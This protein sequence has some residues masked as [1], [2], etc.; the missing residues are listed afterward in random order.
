MRRIRRSA[1]GMLYRSPGAGPIPVI[2]FV[3]TWLLMGLASSVQAE[4]YT[5]YTEELPPYVMRDGKQISG[6]GVDVVTELFR[7][8]GY[9]FQVKVLP[10]KRAYL[11]GR[12]EENSCVF[13]VQRSQE[14]EVLFQWVSPIFISHSAFYSLADASFRIRSLKDVEN[15]T[16][17]SYLGSGD[18]EYLEDQGFELEL[19][20]TNLSNMRKLALKRLDVW[21]VDT[22]TASYLIQHF[23]EVLLK[24]Q[25]VYFTTLRALGCNLAVPEPVIAGLNNALKSMYADGTVDRILDGYR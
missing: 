25:L 8:A 7:R 23:G 1:R 15:L 20:S 24:K 16:I 14:N 11:M 2:G 17:G 18:A 9:D 3:V 4:T 12:T 13:P 10:W 6:A 5:L 22:L 19:T 21:A